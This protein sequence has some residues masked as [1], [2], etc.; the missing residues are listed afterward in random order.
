MVIKLR[1]STNELTWL[2]RLFPGF[3][4]AVIFIS[5]CGVAKPPEY[6]RVIVLQGTHY[7]MGFQQGRMFA[8]EIRSLY[9]TLL[10]SSLLP[11]LNRDQADIAGVLK[12]Y[13]GPD[14]A[15]GKFSKH[16]LMDSAKKLESYV[17]KYIKDEM[18]GIADGS[19]VSY[20]HVLLLNMLLDA[21][22]NMRSITFFIRLMDAPTL[23]RVD[24]I[25]KD[26][27]SADGKAIPD[28]SDSDEKIVEDYDPSPYAAMVEMPVDGGVRFWLRDQVGLGKKTPPEGVDQESIRIQWNDKVLHLGDPGV[29]VQDVKKDEK[30]Y[31]VVTFQPSK[32]KKGLVKVF[33]KASVVSVQIQ[34]GDKAVVTSSPPPH[35]HMMR[36]ERIVFTTEGYGKKAY[37]VPNKGAADPRFQPPSLAFGV[38]GSATPDHRVRLAQHFALLDSNTLH[39]HTVV[40]FCKPKGETPFMYVGWTGLT[41]GFSGMNAKGLS[42]AADLSDTL[43]NGM[44]NE[45]VHHIMDLQNAK[46][47]ASGVPAGIMGREILSRASTVD[48]AATILKKQL[49]SFGWI[50]ALADAKAGLRVVEM[51]QDIFKKKQGYSTFTVPPASADDKDDSGRPWAS[52][53]DDDIRIASNGISLTNDIDQDLFGLV[54]L[55]PQRFWTSFYFRSL[56]AF[57]ILGD[58]IKQAYGHLDTPTIVDI[59]RTDSIVDH[60]DSM[61]SVVF[62]PQTLDV[63]VASG[64]VPATNGKYSHFN[65]G[66]PATW[67]CGGQGPGIGGIDE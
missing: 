1:Y 31:T 47:E 54:T 33:A 9:T 36:D 32:A 42:Y 60:R 26:G 28:L 62:E 59:L 45:L 67:V 55:R 30:T 51:N 56:R 3:L 35:A 22:F 11:Y 63:Y 24:F 20:D 16:F 5:G 29:S 4:L 7:E 43:N 13:A 52:V 37:E 14:Y 66:D 48:E 6:Q 65:L 50:F 10:T 61:N 46:M 39:K 21:M 53:G 44:V 18:H 57:Y 34:S 8:N 41:W 19:G 12:F 25:T 2:Q 58:R 23:T 49:P 15:D 27:K 38:R 17:P 40:F 64:E